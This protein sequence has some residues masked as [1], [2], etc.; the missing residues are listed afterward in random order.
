VFGVA[1]DGM[2]YTTLRELVFWTKSGDTHLTYSMA[3]RMHNVNG[4]FEKISMAIC[5][6]LSNGTPDIS[7]EL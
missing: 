4:R 1:L 2:P 6:G 7:G 3:H 5:C